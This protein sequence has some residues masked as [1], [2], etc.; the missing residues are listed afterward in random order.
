MQYPGRKK[1][2]KKKKCSSPENGAGSSSI[3]HDTADR[4]T[5]VTHH[6]SQERSFHTQNVDG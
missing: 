6:L 5:A 3:L 1:K 4:N 2:K